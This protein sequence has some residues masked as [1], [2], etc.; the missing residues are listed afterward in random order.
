ML[1]FYKNPVCSV[2]GGS[3]SD[4]VIDILERVRNG[5][6]VQ[7]VF[8][9]TG[10]EYDVTKQHLDYLEERYHISISRHKAEVPVPL[11]CK[12]H[13]QPFISKNISQY[14]QRLQKHG[15][16][17]EDEPLEILLDRYSGCQSALKWWCNAWGEGSRFNIQKNKYL[18]EFIISN[19]PRF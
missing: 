19:P 16:Q 5:R 7:Y 17:W 15:F 11:G 18:K 2:S 8:Y 12:K 14:I 9:D 3:D 6:P 13:G 10:I 1:T 4:I